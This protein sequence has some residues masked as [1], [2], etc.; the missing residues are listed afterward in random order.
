MAGRIISILFVLSINFHA[1]VSGADECVE[2]LKSFIAA[3]TSN[4]TE[5]DNILTIKET[6]YPQNDT[7]SPHY[8]FVYYCYQEPCDKENKNYT[9]IWSDSRIFFVVDYYLFSSLTFELA[10]LGNVGTVSFVVPVPCDNNTEDLL[11]VLT[12]QVTFNF[13]LLC[14]FSFVLH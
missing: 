13:Y 5:T 10:D 14:N 4:E 7:S 6:F 1:F 3:F 11:L 2:D 8:A 9:Y 12:A